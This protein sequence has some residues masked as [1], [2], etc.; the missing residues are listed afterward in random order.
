MGANPV[1]VIAALL[2]FAVIIG[3]GYVTRKAS[4]DPWTIMWPDAKSAPL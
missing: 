1:V 2:Y 4:A 3:I